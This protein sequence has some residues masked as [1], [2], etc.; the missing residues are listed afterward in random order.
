M[1]SLTCVV[2]LASRVSRGIARYS[3]GLQAGPETH[4][5]APG[6]I[7]TTQTPSAL[8]GVPAT[9]CLANQQNNNTSRTPPP[10]P[11]SL[12]L[13][14][15]PCDALL[16]YAVPNDSPSST[17]DCPVTSSTRLRETPLMPTDPLP[18][19]RPPQVHFRGVTLAN[20]RGCRGGV[21]GRCNGGAL[22][23]REGTWDFA[24]VMPL[25]VN[26]RLPF[27]PIF[28]NRGGAGTGESSN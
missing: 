22:H 27:S 11:P 2:A 21:N 28:R 14:H 1:S 7:D 17:R 24:T 20:H 6:R 19:H 10:S 3:M 26:Y 12:P 13:S 25:T 15:R 8:W 23:V 5:W 4:K 18:H 9:K 16:V